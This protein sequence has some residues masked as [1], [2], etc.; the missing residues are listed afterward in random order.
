MKT[1]GLELK[2]TNYYFHDHHGVRDC[3]EE[4]KSGQN[5]E[6]PLGTTCSHQLGPSR[7]RQAVTHSFIVSQQQS[8]KKAYHSPPVISPP[9]LH[10]WH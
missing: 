6:S 1:T 3:P 9:G 7:L 5:A 8:K 10:C 4:K 2:T